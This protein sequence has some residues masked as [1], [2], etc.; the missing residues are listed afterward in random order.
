MVKPSA[1]LESIGFY[2][3]AHQEYLESI[4]SAFDIERLAY[5]LE[6]KSSVI[7]HG[8]QGPTGKSTFAKYLREQGLVAMELAEYPTFEL[9]EFVIPVQRDERLWRRFEVVND[10][11]LEEAE[12]LV[13]S[14]QLSRQD[15]ELLLNTFRVRNV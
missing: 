12:L 15:L 7:V 5:I 14:K 3:N 6:G 4:L 8:V 10:N 11:N 13:E 1:V 9:N 2:K